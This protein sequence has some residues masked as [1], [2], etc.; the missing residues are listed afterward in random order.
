MDLNVSTQSRTFCIENSMYEA[1]IPIT[2]EPL[3]SYMLCTI[4]KVRCHELNAANML[5]PSGDLDGKPTLP[6]GRDTTKSVETN[7]VF[8]IGNLDDDLSISS[9]LHNLTEDDSDELSVETFFIIAVQTPGSG[10]SILLAVGTP[11]TGSGNLYCQ[12]ELSPGKPSTQTPPLLNIPVTV[13]PETLSAAASTIPLLIPPLTLIPQTS[14]PTSAPTTEPTTTSISALLK[15]SSLFGFNQRVSVLE[16]YISQIKQVDYS[17]QLLKTVKSQ[18]PAMV[19][20]QHSTRLEDSIKK[21]FRQHKDKDLLVGSDQWLKRRKTN[22]DVEPSKLSKSKE[23][24]SSS[25]KGNKSQPKSSGKSAQAEESVFKTT[26]TEMPQNQGSDLGNTDDKPNV[27]DAS[28]QAV[29]DRLD[30]NNPKGQEYPFDLTKPLPLIEDRGHQVV[31]VNYFIN[32][33]L[34]YLKGRSSSRK[35]TTSTTKTKAA[36]YDDIQGI[37]DMV[38]T[39]WSLM[40]VAYDI[41]VVWGITYWGPKRQRF[42]RYA[43]NRVSKHD[44][45]STKRI[46]AVTHV[47]VMKWYDYGLNLRDIKDMLLRV[48]QKKI[49]NLEKN[50]IFDFNVA[51]WMFT[52]R[53]VILKRVEDLQLGVKS[54]QKKLNITNP[55]TFRTDIP[56]TTPY[57]NPQGII[58]VD[59]FKRNRLMRSDNLY[60]FSDG[61]LTSVRSV[62]HDIASNLRIDYLLEDGVI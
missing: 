44:V 8:S 10:I 45:F 3:F 52:K 11:S 20:A 37:K 56:K 36:K 54:Y 1:L 59:K 22:K 19:N 33:D 46:I 24:K 15:V 53:A 13:I 9:S 18:I 48:V 30:W 49:A 51:L 25:S 29:T 28:E 43:S 31:H 61:T 26:G 12:W 42:Y 5:G 50:V 21:S 27:E 58:Y 16:R 35:Y 41:Y 57:N 14:T 62:L 60:K 17:A 2:G 55:E 32:N 38:T 23:S 7:L 34:E 40:K 47:R 39:L 6:N 4:V